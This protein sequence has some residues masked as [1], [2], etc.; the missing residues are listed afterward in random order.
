M[1]TAAGSKGKV[2]ESR[3]VSKLYKK[4]DGKSVFEKIMD[5]FAYNT[6]QEVGQG[7][8]RQQPRMP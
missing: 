8:Q 1:G 4:K 7:L 5:K 3:D 2:Y 6:S